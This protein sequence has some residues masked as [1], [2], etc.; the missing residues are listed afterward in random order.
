MGSDELVI[1][2]EE[3]DA[4]KGELDVDARSEPWGFL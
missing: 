1:A 3:A 4:D 2:E